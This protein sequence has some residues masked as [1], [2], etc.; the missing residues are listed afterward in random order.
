MN[1]ANVKLPTRKTSLRAGYDVYLPEDIV[2]LDPGFKKIPLGI[3][4]IEGSLA[5]D[6]FISVLPRSS[7]MAN[8]MIIQGVI[9]SDYK[10]ELF[11]IVHHMCMIEQYKGDSIA[12]FIIQKYGNPLKRETSGGE[13]PAKRQKVERFGVM[14]WDYS[15]CVVEG[16][17]NTKYEKYRKGNMTPEKRYIARGP[18]SPFGS[19]Y[20]SPRD[21]TPAEC[22]D[23]YEV[24]LRSN[25]NLMSLLRS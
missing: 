22:L 10:D 6:E 20:L 4:L 15:N 9:D 18:W 11:L 13:P 24:Y 5:E 25:E 2:D 3:A 14:Q 12:Q 23:K 19:P 7:A 17:M 8:G 16:L 21:G 1:S